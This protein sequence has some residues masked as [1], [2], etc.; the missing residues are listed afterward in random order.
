MEELLVILMSMAPLVESRIAI[1]YG[2]LVAGLPFVKTLLLAFFGGAVAVLVAAPFLYRFG[3]YLRDRIKLL[4]RV[5]AR[6]QTKHSKRF[7]EGELLALF[8]LVALPVPMSGIWTGILVSYVFGIS[9]RKAIL[10]ILAGA[11]AGS[12]AVGILTTGAGAIFGI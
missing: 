5:L 8:I 2:I 11:L 6:T 7:L 3:D 12:I 1:P 9:Q 10:V 4:K